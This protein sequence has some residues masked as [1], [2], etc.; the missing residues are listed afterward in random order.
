MGGRRDCMTN[1]AYTNLYVQFMCIIYKY[2]VKTH[3][4]EQLLGRMLTNSHIY[5]FKLHINII[6][7][8][9]MGQSM[10][11]KQKKPYSVISLFCVHIARKLQNVLKN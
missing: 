4:A 3:L 5:V 10:P 8:T 9:Y 6:H 1:I 11:T 7:E 2:T